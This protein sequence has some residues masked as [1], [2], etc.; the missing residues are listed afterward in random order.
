MSTTRPLVSDGFFYLPQLRTTLIA[1]IRGLHIACHVL[2]GLLLVSLFPLLKSTAQHHIVKYW[3]R[4]LLDIL[5]V[6][7]ETQGYY[8]TD[9]GQGRLLLANHVSWLDAVALNAVLPACFVAK[10]EVGNWP[11]L[12]WILH[13]IHT[14]FIKRD[15]KMDTIRIN[16]QIAQILNRGERVALFPQ[17]TTT[18]GRQL[19]HF[20]SSLLQGAIE[21]KAAIFPVAIHYHDG[22]GTTT[23]DAAFIGEMTFLQSLWKIL[24][25][26]ALHVTLRYLPALP[27]TGKNRRILA[28]EAQSAIYQALS[29][30]SYGPFR[31]TPDGAVISTWRDAILP[32]TRAHFI[33]S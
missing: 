12:G 30:L 26:P 33:N 32:V 20:H 16:R 9:T 29:R 17:G 25:S 10:S 23:L 28:A 19:G 11:L 24:C 5:H 13:G 6:G 18:D 21:S 22:S 1:A 7:L 4:K 8:P 27:G 2:Y 14:L 3:S 31:H 15:C